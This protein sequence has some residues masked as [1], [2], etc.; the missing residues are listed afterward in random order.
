MVALCIPDEDE[1][2]V[3][4]PRVPEDKEEEVLWRPP[5]KDDVG[6]VL[7]VK[8]LHARRPGRVRNPSPISP[9]RSRILHEHTFWHARWDTQIDQDA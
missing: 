1:D 7:A 2:E 3:P 4:A 6:G 9:S 5:K 8:H